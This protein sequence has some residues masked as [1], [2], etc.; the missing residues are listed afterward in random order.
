[1]IYKKIKHRNRTNPHPIVMTAEEILMKHF[2]A[3][4]PLATSTE[5]TLDI[6]AA[7][8]DYAREKCKE[9]QI[10]M[11]HTIAHAKTETTIPFPTFD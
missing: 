6:V 8:K 11:A 10:I 5:K 3:L 9:Q 7:M 4:S 2:D 1:M